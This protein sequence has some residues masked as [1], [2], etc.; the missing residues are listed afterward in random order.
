MLPGNSSVFISFGMSRIDG[1]ATGCRIQLEGQERTVPYQGHADV[2]R[3]NR[4]E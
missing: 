1:F 4:Y 2:D 3:R